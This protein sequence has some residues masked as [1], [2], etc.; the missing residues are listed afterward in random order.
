MPECECV[1]TPI[2][3]RFGLPTAAARALGLLRSTT[4]DAAK[5]L[6]VASAIENL[7]LR[8]DLG[9]TQPYD[10]VVLGN[11]FFVPEGLRGVRPTVLVQEG[12][13]W[14]YSWRR[15]LAATRL[16]PPLFASANGIGLSHSYDYFCVASEGYKEA[17]AK[18]G[19]GRHRMVVTGLPGLDRVA[20]EFR[21][22]VEDTERRFV[23][24]ITHPGREYQEGENRQRLLNTASSKSKGRPIVVKLHPNENHERATREVRELLPE[25]TVLID[26]DTNNLVANCDA[27]ITTYSTVIYSA[28]L[29]GK[30]V[31]CSYPI[32]EIG[33]L[34][35]DQN[36]CAAERIAD[37]CRMALG[38]RPQSAM[39]A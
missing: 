2:F 32:K 13:V 30:E 14:P 8:L 25:A 33:R 37:T 29:L 11:D 15:R 10:L 17:F 26:A 28:L 20:S 5:Q 34:L 31:H 27:L 12:W 36:G 21:P 23:L 9:A 7:G 4:L 35:P 3:S 6:R 22:L 39:A 38:G 19:I 1:F 18:S 16:V 24:V